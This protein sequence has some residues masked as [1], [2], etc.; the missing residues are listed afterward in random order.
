MIDNNDIVSRLAKRMMDA[1]DRAKYLT[2]ELEAA[3]AKLDEWVNMHDKDITPSP[4][5][6]PVFED[7]GSLQYRG[8]T[9]SYIYDKCEKYGKEITRLNAEL[10]KA[11]EPNPAL[12]NVQIGRAHV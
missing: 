5:V 11:K 2:V 3:K 9:V 10:A 4:Q 12:E 8:N 1:E 7:I 6:N